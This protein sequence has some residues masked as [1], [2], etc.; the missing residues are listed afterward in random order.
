MSTDSLGFSAAEAL[1]YLC[2][3]RCGRDWAS[4]ALVGLTL[5]AGVAVGLARLLAG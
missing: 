1:R 3:S 5:V 2:A 4:K